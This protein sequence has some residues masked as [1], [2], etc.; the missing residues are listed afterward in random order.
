MSLQLI[1]FDEPK[2]VPL[3]RN[4]L[5]S[6]FECRSSPSIVP[7]ASSTDHKARST[8]ETE[9]DHHAAPCLEALI[10]CRWDS[11]WTK[12][13]L[14]RLLSPR[15]AHA[16][17]IHQ[18]LCFGALPASSQANPSIHSSVLC[19]DSY[20]ARQIPHGRVS[21]PC[22]AI[23]GQILMLHTVICIDAVGLQA[24]GST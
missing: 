8:S 18:C 10:E 14:P 2:K 1:S 24:E 3:H 6:L 20:L 19:N 22:P 13:A 17:T 9:N 23:H 15:R 5:C 12:Q 11:V 7:M 21:E 16:V 4:S